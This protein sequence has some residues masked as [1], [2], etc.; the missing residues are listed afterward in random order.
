M[1]GS[2]TVSFGHQFLLMWADRHDCLGAPSIGIT[3]RIAE[4]GGAGA[5]CRSQGL[6]GDPTMSLQ[7][8][9]E[10]IYYTE[11][12]VRAL[13]DHDEDQARAVAGFYLEGL[14]PGRLAQRIG[15]DRRRAETLL[16]CAQSWVG[17]RLME[18]LPQ[19]VVVREGTYD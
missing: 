3:G 15:V 4:E 8:Q 10:H 9:R 5:A 7:I 6:H 12:A 17:A 18:T 11:R 14:T 2:N 13:S 16:E 1:K 19:H